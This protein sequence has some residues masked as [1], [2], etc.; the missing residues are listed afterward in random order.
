MEGGKG[1][2]KEKTLEKAKVD[3]VYEIET[4]SVQWS[5][6]QDG[7]GPLSTKEEEIEL[8]YLIQEGSD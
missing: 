3:N 7:V 5:L 8:E 6:K 1:L 4:D 2:N